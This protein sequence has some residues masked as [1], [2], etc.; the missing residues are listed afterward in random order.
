M[1][2]SPRNKNKKTTKTTKYKTTEDKNESETHD[3]Y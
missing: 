1:V 2:R 3:Q